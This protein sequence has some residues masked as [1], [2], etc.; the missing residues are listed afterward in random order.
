M[1]VVDAVYL[2][3]RYMH[4]DVPGVFDPGHLGGVAFPA[5]GQVPQ[6]THLVALVIVNGFPLELAEKEFPYYPQFF[7]D[8]ASL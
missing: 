4:L 3:H 7:H 6:F 5:N 8:F 1:V 2:V